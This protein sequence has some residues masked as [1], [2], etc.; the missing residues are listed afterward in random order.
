M[1]IRDIAS[2]SG[3]SLGTV[4]RV[5]N[6][7]PNVSDTARERILAV[8]EEQ[9]YRPNS[10][11]RH[12]K[13]QARTS[14]AAFVKGTN[15]MLFASI[16]ERIQRLVIDAGE[17]V[18]VVYMDE[19]SNE[20]ARAKTYARLRSTKGIM[21]LGGDLENFA[22]EFADL[23][24]LPCVLVSNSA[25]D[26]GFPN[27]SSITTDDV[28]AASTAVE[29]LLRH[30]HRR[31]GIIGGNRA[32]QQISKR[33]LHGAQVALA[34]YGIDFDD[35]T[36]FEPCHFSLN[37]GYEAVVNLLMRSPDITG[38]F[39]LGD[40]VAIGALRA[41]FDMGRS[42]PEDISIVGFDGIDFSQFIQP[43]LTTIH[44]DAALMAQRSL[45]VLMGMA[46]G[47]IAEPVH[48]IIPFTLYRRESV[49]D[50]AEDTTKKGERVSCDVQE[51]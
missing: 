35:E 15:N 22:N 34:R 21:F 46:E 28:E 33:R 1:N 45:E 7:R 42:V 37:D 30:G 51:S 6:G 47:S 36:D 3:Y 39:A 41:L 19:D 40:V 27:L 9:G 50:V 14:F 32:D 23:G 13:M 25:G 12:L 44:Q 2:L 49:L 43:R 17:A 5:L 31:I 10:N 26:L 11:A 8:I 4:S 16:V 29:E 20:I 38:I 18:H 48:E 24:D